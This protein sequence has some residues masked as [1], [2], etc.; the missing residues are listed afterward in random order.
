VEGVIGDA[1]HVKRVAESHYAAEGGGQRNGAVPC[2]WTDWPREIVTSDGVGPCIVKPA[3]A[4]YKWLVAPKLTTHAVRGGV[5]RGREPTT[6]AN[7]V[8]KPAAFT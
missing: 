4:I 8:N 7:E 2:E 5:A 1:R 6:K 3:R